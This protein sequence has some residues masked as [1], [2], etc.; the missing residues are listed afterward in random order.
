MLI[1]KGLP[2]GEIRGKLICT[3]EEAKELFDFEMKPGAQGVIIRRYTYLNENNK[4]KTGLFISNYTP[5][6]NPQTKKQQKNRAKMRDAVLHWQHLPES[7][8]DKYRKRAEQKHMSGFNLH[9]RDFLNEEKEVP[10][11]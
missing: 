2:Y 1:T 4:K 8:K 9:N 3:P 5:P 7:E 11:A 6:T 10:T